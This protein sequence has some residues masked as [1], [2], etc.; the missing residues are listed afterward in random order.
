M[1]DTPDEITL[2]CTSGKT[3]GCSGLEAGES[4]G[5][6]E[7]VCDA[8]KCHGVPPKPAEDNGVDGA[9]SASVAVVII[10]AL[11]AALAAKLH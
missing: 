8:I 11:V 10:A 9:H 3:V 1:E 2:S 4:Y 6:E 5:K 7:C